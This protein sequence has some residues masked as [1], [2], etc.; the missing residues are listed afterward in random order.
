VVFI[1]ATL[2]IVPHNQVIASAAIKY[3]HKKMT[4][5][6]V[7]HEH[8]LTE[9]ERVLFDSLVVPFHEADASGK[10]NMRSWV[11]E[12]CTRIS[13]DEI[14]GGQGG[15]ALD[16]NHII[17]HLLLLCE[18][19]QLNKLRD[20]VLDWMIKL[21]RTDNATPVALPGDSDWVPSDKMPGKVILASIIPDSID[22]Q[23]GM[24]AYAH[25][26]NESLPVIQLIDLHS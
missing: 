10:C 21:D 25:A 16:M 12:R 13:V 24:H 14:A 15:S 5:Q 20:F 23:H 11:G 3:R 19:M 18:K 26:E 2:G 22:N 9:F 17:F 8:Q 1:K 4:V 7:I 6:T